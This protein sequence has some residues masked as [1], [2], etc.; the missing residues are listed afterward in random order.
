MALSS[1]QSATQLVTKLALRLTSGD[2]DP[3]RGT[4]T[5]DGRTVFSVYDAMRNTSAYPTYGAVKAAWARLLESEFKEEVVLQTYHIKFP[6]QGQ[7]LTPCMDIRGLQ[8]LIA[9]LGGKIGEEYRR[10]VETTLT[11]LVA[12]DET[13]I[14]EIEQNAGSDAPMQTLAQEALGAEHMLGDGAGPM[15]DSDDSMEMDEEQRMVVVRAIASD[16]KRFAPLVPIVKQLAD[17]VALIRMDRDRQASLRHQADGRYGSDIRE[18]NKSVRE[19]AEL[20]RK[21]PI[22]RALHQ[23][24]Q[25]LCLAEQAGMPGRNASQLQPA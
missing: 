5:A 3:I 13:M 24:S 17:E 22:Q 14:T 4:K 12:G 9:L 11:R 20:R 25:H 21:R 10:L 2:K 18:A 23:H 15:D 16:M 8:R 1:P 19:Q 6:G 7:R